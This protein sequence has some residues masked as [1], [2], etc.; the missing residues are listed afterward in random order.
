MA[1][2]KKIQSLLDQAEAEIEQRPGHR[3]ADMA[4]AVG[5]LINAVRELLVADQPKRTD[6]PKREAA[7]PTAI[8]ARRRN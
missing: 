1:D 5:L 6:Q 8:P 2:L 4:S 7:P 3:P